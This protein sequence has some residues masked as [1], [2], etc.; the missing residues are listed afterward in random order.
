M[1]PT[2]I[3]AADLLAASNVSARV[4]SMHT[5]KPLDEVVLADAFA[6]TSLVVTIEEHSVIGGLG[7]AVA[8][9]HSEHA[10][11]GGKLLRIGTPDHFLHEAGNQRH[12]RR[13]LK[14]D[15]QSIATRILQARLAE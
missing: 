3:E 13:V 7:G 10:H 8:E 11:S 5:V 1:L 9:W 14:L 15:T 6:A 4:Y 12:A 2:A